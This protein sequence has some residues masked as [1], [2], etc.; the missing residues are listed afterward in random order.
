MEGAELTSEIASFGGDATELQSSWSGCMQR[1]SM[2]AEIVLVETQKEV[3]PRQA[4]RRPQCKFSEHRTRSSLRWCEA[5]KS[6]TP[7]EAT[8]KVHPM[9]VER[10]T[11][12]A[13][14]KRQ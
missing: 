2:N 7:V 1:T 12:H 5:A 13:R 4:A 14:R 9:C 8:L 10:S 6:E 3:G 11:Y